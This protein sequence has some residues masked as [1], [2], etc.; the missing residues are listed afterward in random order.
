M[1]AHQRASRL[2]RAALAALALVLSVPTPAHADDGEVER[3]LVTRMLLTAGVIGVSPST[4]NPDN[5]FLRIPS[6]T[7]Q[8]ELRPDIAVRLPHLELRLRPRVRAGGQHVA[9]NALALQNGNSADVYLLEWL[10]RWQA[11]DDLYVS[12]G[13]ENVQWGPSQLYS[14]SNP[15]FIENNRGNPLAEGFGTHF[16]RAVWAPSVHMSLSLL[17]DVLPAAAPDSITSSD[18]DFERTYALKLDF[19]D[20]SR[21][22]SVIAAH[23]DDTLPVQIGGYAVWTATDALVLYTEGR[24]AWWKGALYPFAAPNPFGI[25]LATLA[26]ER[27]WPT[28]LVGGTYTFTSGLT[29]TGEYLY[30]GEGYD[31]HQA[32]LY[33]DL[34]AAAG[35]SFQAKDTNQMVASDLLAQT[36]RPR[37][38]FLRRNYA[39]LQLHYGFRDR[40]ELVVRYLQN[41]DDAGLALAPVLIWPVGTNLELVAMG[42]AHLGPLRSELRS[43][44]DYSAMGGF[45]VTF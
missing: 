6:S 24:L 44:V 4:Q 26:N 25:A 40:G 36:A 19:T 5:D 23:G 11:T 18:K 22:V 20:E 34:R 33:F 15:F 7:W 12:V 13:A 45:T 42:F 37:L 30:S 1:T 31:D 9:A 14:P 21:Q 16:V 17:M 39:L 8:Y 29:L 2:A 41:L 3:S 10:L 43:A 32:D 27:L 38:R 28:I 35:A